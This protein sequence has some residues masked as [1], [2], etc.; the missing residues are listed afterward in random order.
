MQV[1]KDQWPWIKTIKRR[2]LYTDINS[3]STNTYK[4]VTLVT[5]PTNWQ[6]WFINSELRAKFT[7]GTITNTYMNIHD[8][9]SVAANYTATNQFAALNTSSNLVDYN[10][11]NVSAPNRIKTVSGKSVNMCGNIGQPTAYYAC[12]GRDTGSNWN[13]LTGGE[14]DIWLSFVRLT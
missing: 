7:G 10:G 11:N 2:V 5:M 12:F 6:L 13:Q 3:S 1:L 4:Q 14:I 9:N 8:Y